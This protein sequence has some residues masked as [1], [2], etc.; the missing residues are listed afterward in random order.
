MLN[1]NIN[2]KRLASDYY[3]KNPCIDHS[4]VYNA[5]YCG[6]VNEEFADNIISRLNRIY[7]HY[8]F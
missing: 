6:K 1:N 8:C 2:N 5:L 4:E 7:A 3:P